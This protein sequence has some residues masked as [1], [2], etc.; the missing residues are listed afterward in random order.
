V[1]SKLCNLCSTW[2]AKHDISLEPIPPHNCWKNYE[3]TSGAM[4][5]VSCLEMVVNMF[6]KKMCCIHTI[7]I[8]DEASTMDQC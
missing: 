7:C 4:E 5:A 1:K 8:D 6:E 2:T 3:G